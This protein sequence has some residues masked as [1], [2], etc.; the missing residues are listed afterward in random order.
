[1]LIS[2]SLEA[3]R[4][5]P[6]LGRAALLFAVLV[7]VFGLVLGVVSRL[8]PTGA[9][10]SLLGL[11]MLQVLVTGSLVVA[12]LVCSV[13]CLVQRG[14]AGRIPAAIALGASASTVLTL[15]F[16]WLPFVFLR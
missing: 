14:S 6:T 10:E 7:P 4:P 13:A 2:D 11:G 5:S 3:P 8:L 15:G 1:M 16:S 9:S 12:S